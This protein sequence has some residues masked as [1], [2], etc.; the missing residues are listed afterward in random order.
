MMCHYCLAHVW[1]HGEAILSTWLMAATSTLPAGDE[2]PAA[3]ARDRTVA[4][5]AEASRAARDRAAAEAAEASKG[6]RDRAVAEAAGVNTKGALSSSGGNGAGYGQQAGAAPSSSGSSIAADG[7]SA[8]SGSECGSEGSDASK[9]AT[10]DLELPRRSLLVQ[11]TCN[12]C[13]GR[14]GRLVNPVAWD[15]GM[16]RAELLPEAST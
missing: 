10:I 9:V 15:K 3:S 2:R 14:S 1:R 16:V 11:F 8:D 12:V 6:A 7:G 5:A 13:G 4:E